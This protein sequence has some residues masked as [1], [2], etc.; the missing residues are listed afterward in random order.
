MF[1]G[2]NFQ[3]IPT[4]LKKAI[5]AIGS[6]VSAIFFA[7][8]YSNHGGIKARLTVAI[9]QLRSTATAMPTSQATEPNDYHWTIV[10]CLISIIAALLDVVERQGA[11]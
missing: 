1:R 7:E 8:N 5:D 9:K 4:A 10:N 3:R 2:E 6:R 11:R